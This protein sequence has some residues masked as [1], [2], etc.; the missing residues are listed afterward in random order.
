MTEGT[1]MTGWIAEHLALTWLAAAVLLAFVELLSLDFVLLMF[2]L[3]ALT[4][5]AVSFLGA[6]LWVAV[7]TFALGSFVLLFLLRPTLVRRLHAGP[8]LATGFSNLV[9]KDAL[10]L[11]AVGPRQGRVQI[12]S[13][14]WSARTEGGESIDEGVEAHVVAIDGATA[15]VS[16]VLRGEES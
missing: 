10:V 6:P 13:E 16:A 7:T 3:G 8:T 15:V 1:Y 9:G 2:A 5:S 12:G 11:E 4:A 14:E